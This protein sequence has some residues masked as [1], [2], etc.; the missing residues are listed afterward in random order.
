MD[1]ENVDGKIYI[2]NFFIKC[3]LKYG[4]VKYS[5]YNFKISES[6]F[7]IMIDS[8]GFHVGFSKGDLKKLKKGKVFTKSFMKSGSMFEFAIIHKNHKKLV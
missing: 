4:F 1:I 7:D 5:N 8:D 3:L 6:G 2:S